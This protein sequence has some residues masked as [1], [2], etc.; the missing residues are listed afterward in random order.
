MAGR[1]RKETG[2]QPGKNKE[3]EGQEG[4]DKGRIRGKMRIDKEERR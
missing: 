4:E 3:R 1:K 2:N